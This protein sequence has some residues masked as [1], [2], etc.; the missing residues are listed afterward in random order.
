MAYEDWKEL[1]REEIIYGLYKN[2]HFS[3][4]IIREEAEYSKFEW[5]A[6]L[7]GTGTAHSLPN[8][9]ERLKDC[10]EASFRLERKPENV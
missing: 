9:Y 8:A 10:F 6:G 4:K 1:K 7:R 5:T 2:I 3:I